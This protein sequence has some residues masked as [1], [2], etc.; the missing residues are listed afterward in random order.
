MIVKRWKVIFLLC[1]CSL[2][3]FLHLS[4]NEHVKKKK[5]SAKDSLDTILK[6]VVNFPRIGFGREGQLQNDEALTQETTTPQ[7]ATT[8]LPASYTTK[9][10]NFD[11][12]K[13]AIV[14]FPSTTNCS[15]GQGLK[16]K[17]NKGLFVPTLYAY[18]CRK[19]QSPPPKEHMWPIA[20]PPTR[21]SVLE[22]TYVRYSDQKVNITVDLMM[23]HVTWRC[24]G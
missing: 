1:G 20:L 10:N 2:L 4:D 23:S 11:T 17:S 14:V 7:E 16:G 13:Q 12:L 3:V 8:I 18:P 19:W 15:N 5:Q 22:D 6:T 9:E 21:G 24:S